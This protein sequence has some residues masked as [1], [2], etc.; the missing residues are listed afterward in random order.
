M[1]GASL[2]GGTF[3]FSVFANK[4]LLVCATPTCTCAARAT[5]SLKPQ[6]QNSC[7]ETG[8]PARAEVFAASLF[9]EKVCQA[10]QKMSK[11]VTEGERMMHK[12]IWPFWP[13]DQKSGLS[14]TFSTEA[15]CPGS[16]LTSE[17]KAH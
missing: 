1:V 2:C 13:S 17:S 5:F 8:R 16:P 7:Q 6:E 3:V 12:T 9:T 4:V 11:S 15:C 10:H 14:R